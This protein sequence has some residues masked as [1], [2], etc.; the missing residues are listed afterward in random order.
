[1]SKV[2]Q[3]GLL[4]M[5]K[6]T[7]APVASATVGRKRYA[8]PTATDCAGLPDIVG[9]ILCE[10]A[11]GVDEFADVLAALNKPSLQPPSIAPR[12]ATRLTAIAACTV[13]V[14]ASSSLNCLIHAGCRRPTKGGW[15]TAKQLRFHR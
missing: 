3:T 2:A 14:I 11:A 5:A 1:M 8:A 13:D 7:L 10:T 4:I 9:P 6:V 15:F 12:D